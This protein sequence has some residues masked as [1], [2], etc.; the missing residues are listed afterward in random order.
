MI[1]Q[2]P[3]PTTMS[4]FFREWRRDRTSAGRAAIRSPVKS[5][6]PRAPCL[7]PRDLASSPHWARGSGRLPTPSGRDLSTGDEIV[8]PGGSLGPAQIFDS[9]T[10]ALSAAVRLHGGEPVVA[11]RVS[12]D[13]TALAAAFERCLDEDLVLFS[14]GTS[15][16][17]ATTCSRSSRQPARCTSKVCGSSR[18]SRPCLRRSQDAPSSACRAIPC[19]ASPTPTC[20]WR[21]CSAAWRTC[22]RPPRAPCSRGWPARSSHRPAGIRSTRSVWMEQRPFR[23]SRDQG[24]HQPGPRRRILRDTGGRRDGGRGDGGRSDAVLTRTRHPGHP[25]LDLDLISNVEIFHDPE[26]R[27]RSARFHAADQSR[28]SAVTGRAPRARA[29]VAG[30]S[31]RHLVTQLS[32]PVR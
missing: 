26:A 4:R 30:V 7:H 8:A 9:N 21:R 13:R 1:E 2:T 12:D 24:D 3:A 29:G 15:V 10:A 11:P 6:S 32:P 19:R 18:A 31:S 25:D 22:R 14:G 17:D 20:S 23:C 27:R 16:G 28:R 5:Q